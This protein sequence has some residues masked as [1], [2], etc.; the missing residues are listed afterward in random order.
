M[1]L[2]NVLMN[3][4]IGFIA[5]A[6]TIELVGFVRAGNCIYYCDDQVEWVKVQLNVVGEP[7][8]HRC[9]QYQARFQYF[10][11]TDDST[12]DKMTKDLGTT[13]W[14]LYSDTRCNPTCEQVGYPVKAAGSP[15]GRP[16]EEGE[17][18]NHTCGMKVS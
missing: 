15:E 2:K 18:S 1:R 10:L 11:Y 12:L 9:L 4:V 7:V 6:S 13:V 17:A 16:L 5:F 8:S 14:E 3:G